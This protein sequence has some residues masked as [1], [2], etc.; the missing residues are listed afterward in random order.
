MDNRGRKNK[1]DIS[2]T[3]EINISSDTL[4]YS[5]FETSDWLPLSQLVTPTQAL[6]CKEIQ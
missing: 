5:F 1:T 3:F 2:H 4:L 6:W